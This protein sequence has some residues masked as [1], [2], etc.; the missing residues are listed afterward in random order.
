[1]ILTRATFLAADRPRAIAPVVALSRVAV[2]EV[3]LVLDPLV[4]FLS[5]Q[6]NGDKGGS[7]RHFS[8]KVLLWEVF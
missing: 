8:P 1:M 5:D 2:G 6:L 3:I 4:G 7:T